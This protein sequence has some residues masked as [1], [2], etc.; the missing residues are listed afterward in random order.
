MSI[1]LTWLIIIIA[2]MYWILTKGFNSCRPLVNDWNFH[3]EKA[4][5]K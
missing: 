1:I 3:L 2:I 5:P 4:T